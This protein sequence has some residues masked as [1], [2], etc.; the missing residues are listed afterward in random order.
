MYACDRRERHL[1]VGN[2][3]RQR[4]GHSTHY[5]CR[6]VRLFVRLCAACCASSLWRCALP[7]AFPFCVYLQAAAELLQHS[8]DTL[9]CQREGKRFVERSSIK[10]RAATFRWILRWQTGR[11]FHSSLCTGRVIPFSNPKEGSGGISAIQGWVLAC[12]SSQARRVGESSSVRALR[13]L[14]NALGIFPPR[15]PPPL[16]AKLSIAPSASLRMQC[17]TFSRNETLTIADVHQSH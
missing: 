6:V 14:R 12:T 17:R 13:I 10:C 4:L 2:A 11:S 7:F 3:S 8:L 15:C 9:L 1:S 16:A 5:T